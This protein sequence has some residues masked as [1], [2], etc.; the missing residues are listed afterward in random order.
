MSGKH[1]YRKVIKTPNEHNLAVTARDINGNQAEATSFINVTSLYVASKKLALV[2]GNSQYEHSAPLRNP[3]NDARAMAST[4]RDLDF[5]VISV[6]DVTK[7]EMENALK[8]FSARLKD[9]EVALFYYA[10]HGMQMKGK[11]YLIPVDA[12]Y[13]NGESDVEFESINV[14]MLTKVMDN[15]MGGSD[16]LNL[17][18]LDACRN[19]PYRTWMRGG[20]SGLASMQAPSGTLVAFSTAPGSVASDGTGENGLYTGELIKQMQISQRIEDVFINTRIEVERLSNGQ[21][22]PWELAR[23]KGRYFLK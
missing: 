6:A 4:L 22:S 13:E 18:I 5:E 19:N 1:E 11:N 16:R 9:M 2:I 10:G 3:R 15:Y 14:E 20:E 12:K 17:L 7:A 8:K 21:Q 23:L